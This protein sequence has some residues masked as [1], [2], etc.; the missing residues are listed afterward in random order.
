MPV[1]RNQSTTSHIDP[2]AIE[3]QGFHEHLRTLTRNAV[4]VV[5]EEVMREELTHAPSGCLGRVLAGA[6]RLS[7]WNLHP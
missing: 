1:S 2:V 3:R 7:R 4:R 6:Q 5:I